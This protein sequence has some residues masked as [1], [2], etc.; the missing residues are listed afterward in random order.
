MTLTAA[1]PIPDGDPYEY[2]PIGSDGVTP[3]GSLATTSGFTLNLNPGSSSAYSVNGSTVAGTPVWYLL[4]PNYLTPGLGTAG[5]FATSEFSQQAGSGTVVWGDSA[6]SSSWSWNVSDSDGVWS[7]SLVNVQSV[8]NGTVD[9]YLSQSWGWTSSSLSWDESDTATE[10]WSYS[11]DQTTTYG[12]AVTESLSD[13][14]WSTS[15]SEEISGGYDPTDSSYWNNES[16][17]GSYGAESSISES[18]NA[19]GYDSSTTSATSWE[20]VES[21]YSS[22]VTQGTGGVDTVSYVSADV[23]GGYDTSEEV[24]LGTSGSGTYGTSDA[25]SQASSSDQYVNSQNI[26]DYVTTRLVHQR[27]QRHQLLR[28]QQH[29]RRRHLDQRRLVEFEHRRRRVRPASRTATP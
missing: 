23:D 16:G 20:E 9:S 4:A 22:G 7:G 25:W 10:Y 5:Q 12:N 6:S 21:Q 8:D 1:P 11:D 29:R 28:L 14:G 3:V 19:G 26:S 2:A 17:S 27:R 18:V 13:S 15:F 24:E